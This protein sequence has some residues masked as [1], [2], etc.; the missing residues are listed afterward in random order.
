MFRG[1]CLFSVPIYTRYLV[2]A[3]KLTHARNM[4]LKASLPA[5]TSLAE[6]DRPLGYERVY[7]PLHKVANPPFHIQ[8]EYLF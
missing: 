5:M 2:E 8:G 7:L 6:M 4:A 3:A 1:T